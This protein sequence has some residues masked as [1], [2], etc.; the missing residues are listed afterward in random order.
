MFRIIRRMVCVVLISCAVIVTFASCENDSSPS[1]DPAKVSDAVTGGSSGSSA[2]SDPLLVLVNKTHALPD[3]YNPVFAAIPAKYFVSSDNEKIEN[4]FVKEAADGLV[5]MIDAAK[6]MV[7]VSVWSRA[8]AV[9]KNSSRIFR[10]MS[11][12]K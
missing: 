2:A 9:R 4:H 1:S 7:S 3:D 11:T 12:A 6:G 5:N 8:T 10:A